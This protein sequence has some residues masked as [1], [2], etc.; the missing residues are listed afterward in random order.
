MNKK[1]L[2]QKVERLESDLQKANSSQRYY[3]NQFYNLLDEIDELCEDLEESDAKLK[4]CYD[5]GWDKGFAAAW[6]NY[7]SLQQEVKRRRVWYKL[8][9]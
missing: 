3:Q 8:Y 9:L 5:D 4:R 2:K 7:N 6:E 1:K